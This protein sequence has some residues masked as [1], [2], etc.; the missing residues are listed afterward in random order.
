MRQR[1]KLAF[2]KLVII[3]IVPPVWSLSFGQQVLLEQ[4]LQSIDFRLQYLLT[5]N[6]SS[7]TTTALLRL[8][9]QM[10]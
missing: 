6:V 10:W 4:I 3:M 1:S 2:W 9:K 8:M 7:V 5:V